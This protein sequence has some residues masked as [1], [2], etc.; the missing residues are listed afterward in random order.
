M[1]KEFGGN[2]KFQIVS[3]LPNQLSWVKTIILI[4]PVKSDQA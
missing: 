2:E 4:C 3:G 1:T